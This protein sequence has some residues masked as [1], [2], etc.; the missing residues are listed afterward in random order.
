MLQ[1]GGR[2]DGLGDGHAIRD[3][4]VV[5]DLPR[6]DAGDGP[7]EHGH[8]LERPAVGVRSD[9]VIQLAQM[10][11]DALDD[12]ARIGPRRFALGVRLGTACLLIEQRRDRNLAQI[13]PEQDVDGALARLAAGT[14][15]T[16]AYTRPR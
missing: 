5:E 16:C 13:R 10:R 3:V 14:H 11:V 1:H 8:A 7:V 12:V 6:P 2:L 4:V 15:G 9:R